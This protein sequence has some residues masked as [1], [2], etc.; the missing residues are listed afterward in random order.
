M[1]ANDVCVYVRLKK[2]KKKK[3][4]QKTAEYPSCFLATWI[5]IQF[6]L[7]IAGYIQM[8]SDNPILNLESY[9][10]LFYRKSWSYASKSDR[11]NVSPGC[12]A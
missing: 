11:L 5:P 3:N 2:L 4:K 12:I 9:K 7:L 10:L 6:P 1:Q 8:T